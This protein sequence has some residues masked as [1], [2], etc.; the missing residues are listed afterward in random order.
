[1]EVAVVGGRRRSDQLL[2]DLQ[3]KT[4]D[5]FVRGEGQEPEERLCRQISTEIGSGQTG[6][7]SARLVWFTTPTEVVFFACDVGA[8]SVFRAGILN[9]HAV[10]E[11]PL[12]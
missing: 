11:L 8:R 9:S 2:L 6:T 5:L 12:S 1:M 4:V 10:H 3:P 7:F